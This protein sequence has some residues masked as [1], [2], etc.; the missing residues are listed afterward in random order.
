[1]D[2]HSDAPIQLI[3]IVLHETTENSHIVYKMKHIHC[4]LL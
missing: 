2:C 4:L 3:V 1:M